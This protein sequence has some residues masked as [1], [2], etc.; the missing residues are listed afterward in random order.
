M[1]STRVSVLLPL[2]TIF[3]MAAHL[4]FNYTKDYLVYMSIQ[5][6]LVHLSKT[7]LE[8]IRSKSREW[9][10]EKFDLVSV[11]KYA[12]AQEDGF[13]GKGP[14]TFRDAQFM[15]DAMSPEN[16]ETIPQL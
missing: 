7:Q 9:F 6:E 8:S 15:L 14:I 12:S 11:E 1:L 2:E 10:I 4:N 5:K 3:E 13:E 16:L